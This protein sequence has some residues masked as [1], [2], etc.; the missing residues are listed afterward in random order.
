VSW[1][2]SSLYIGRSPQACSGKLEIFP[3][4]AQSRKV[5]PCIQ[6]IHKHL[7]DSC[8]GLQQ[9]QELSVLTW[10]GPQARLLTVVYGFG[11]RVPLLMVTDTSSSP[12]K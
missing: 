6:L 8:N 2:D 12:E 1:I 10:F 3:G 7:Y 5:L 9:L 4:C 11:Q